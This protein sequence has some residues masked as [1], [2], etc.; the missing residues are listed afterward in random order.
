M[1]LTVTISAT[2]YLTALIGYMEKKR[3]TKAAH[4][5]RR[6]G[7]RTPRTKRQR[8]EWEE[9]KKQLEEALAQ[10]PQPSLWNI[11][12]VQVVML[13]VSLVRGCPEMTKRCL[14]YIKTSWER[15]LQERRERKE[16]QR[17]E[18]KKPKKN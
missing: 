8:Q 1:I 6:F 13:V 14:T 7:T 9:G 3:N 4:S 10:I 17:E 18:E 2:Q 16:R 11:L 5:K 15:R 12:P